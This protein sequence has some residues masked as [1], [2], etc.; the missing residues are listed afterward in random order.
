MKYCRTV[1]TGREAK[2]LDENGSGI[3][4]FFTGVCVNYFVLLHI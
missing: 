2:T 4:A 1:D 3:G